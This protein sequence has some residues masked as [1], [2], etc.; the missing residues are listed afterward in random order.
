MNLRE[1]VKGWVDDRKGLDDIRD[2][3]GDM[4]DIL[5]KVI[6]AIKSGNDALHGQEAVSIGNRLYFVKRYSGIGRPASILR[7]EGAIDGTIKTVKVGNLSPE[8][9]AALKAPGRP[10]NVVDIGKLA[11][12]G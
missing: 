11:A 10:I 7:Y 6:K 4:R 1:R 5:G 8:Y 9:L 3:I 2:D 12:E